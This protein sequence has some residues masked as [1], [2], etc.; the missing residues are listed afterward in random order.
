MACYQ[1]FRKA[2]YRMNGAVW[3]VRTEQLLVFVTMIIF[4][5][6][7]MCFVRPCTRLD[8]CHP[9]DIYVY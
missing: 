5:Q 2:A 3:E 9:E 6:F 4:D 1:L 8:I 7:L